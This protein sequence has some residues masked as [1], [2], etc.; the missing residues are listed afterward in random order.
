MKGAGKVFSPTPFKD[1]TYAA[2]ALDQEGDRDF[3]ALI[4]AD[5]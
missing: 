3:L 5:C 2:H 4:D 1:R